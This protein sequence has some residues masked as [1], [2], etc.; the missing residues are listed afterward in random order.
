MVLELNG[1]YTY[2]GCQI[3]ESNKIKIVNKSDTLNKGE[4]NVNKKCIS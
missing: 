3:P 4:A 1:A 2:S